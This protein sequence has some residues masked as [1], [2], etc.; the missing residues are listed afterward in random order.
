MGKLSSFV[1]GRLVAGLLA[2]FTGVFG[3]FG[4]GSTSWAQQSASSPA[5]AAAASAATSAVA[6]SSAS[7]WGATPVRAR[8]DHHVHLLSPDLVRDW[9]SLGVPFSRPDTFYSSADAVVKP[10]GVEKAVILSMAYLYGSEGFRRLEGAAEKEYEWVRRENDFIASVARRQPRRLAGFYGVHPLRP[11][12]LAELRR[13]RD[14]L[15][16]TG[17]KLHLAHAEVDLTNAEHFRRLAEIFAFAAERSTPMLLH[18]NIG[19]GD[20]GR[21]QVQ[22]LARE[23]IGRHPKL[24]VIIA[25]LGGYGSYTSRPQRVLEGFT[26]HLSRGGLLAKQQ[27]YFE[28]SAVVLRE[29]SEGVEPPSEERLKQ[30]TADLR[31]I[32]LHRVLFGS[33]HPVFDSQQYAQTLRDK[34]GMT[35]REI[36]QILGNQWTVLQRL[37]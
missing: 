16:M 6:A 5:V 27:V 31:K 25:H 24:T 37:R 9:K 4:G 34:L 36:R 20:V 33:D 2:V 29:S 22:I 28:L 23:L 1:G 14:E 3:V 10:G 30:L 12:A 17:I 21:Q 35:E 32:G 26:P 15:K 7:S 18:L 8:F 11:Y 13:C 19:S